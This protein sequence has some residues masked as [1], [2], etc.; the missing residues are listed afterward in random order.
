M[1]RPLHRWAGLA[2][3]LFLSVTALSGAALSLYPAA[4][5]LGTPPLPAISVADL[6]ERLGSTVPGLEEIRVSASGRITAYAFDAGSAARWYVDGASGEILGPALRSPLQLW[7]TNLHR[8]LFLGDAGRLVVATASLAMLILTMSGLALAVP[9]LGGIRAFFVPARGLWRQRLHLDLGRVAA[10]GLAVSALTGLWLAADSFDLLPRTHAPAASVTL[11]LAD[12]PAAELRQLALPRPGVP[13]DLFT[14]RTVAGSGHADPLSGV[15]LDWTP[16]SAAE[17]LSALAIRLHSGRGA[18]ALGLM[19]GLSALCVPLLGLTGLVQQ[20][21]RRLGPGALRRV[22]AVAPGAA[23]TILLVGS[24]GGTTWGFAETLRAGLVRAGCRVHVAP[25]AEFAP[26]RYLSARQVLILAATSGAGDA[27]GSARGFLDRLAA[28]PA[29]PAAP[30]ALLGFGDSSFPAFCG[31]ADKVAAAARAAGWAEL[32]PPA[33]VDRQSAA[34]F[35]RW[36][37]ALA[38]RLGLALELAPPVA[39]PVPLRL[40]LVSRR[41]YGAEVQ[42]PAAILRFALPR[43]SLWQRLTGQGFGAFRAGD[44]LAVLPEGDTRPRYYSLASGSEDG[45]AEICVR[46]HPGGLCSGQLFELSPGQTVTAFLRPNPGFHAGPGRAPLILI[47]AGTGIGPLAGFVRANRSGRPI[48]LYFGARTAESD[49]LYGDE[50][51]RWMR[52]GRLAGLA[53]A[54]SRSAE[55]AYVQD[56][57]RRDAERVA[58]LIGQGAQVMVCGGRAMAAGVA[59][60]FDEILSGR[61]ASLSGLKAE[62]RYVEDVY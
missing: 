59:E 38:E 8:A 36:G 60:A 51:A 52:D 6:A 5:A 14:L 43:R 24:E 23:D 20:A 49:L 29:P 4:E 50:L 15:L 45:F 62:G 55:R 18:A 3:A 25:M 9:R 32:M 21:G 53:T 47:G 1:I 57:L 56:L 61:E 34:D 44:L 35:A 40:R 28:L 48:R 46:K 2:A 27:P 19:L 54:F 17:R 7:L 58:G 39:P 11:S 37:H 33:R 42:A 26:A 12:L 13:G 10:A 22:R 30:F 31:Y 16:A 41:D